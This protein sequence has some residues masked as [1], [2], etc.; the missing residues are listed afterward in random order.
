MSPT[1]G[2]K[3]GEAKSCQYCG[4][5]IPARASM[6]E[7]C[8][9]YLDPEL[10][11]SAEG[12]CRETLARVLPIAKA[13]KGVLWCVLVQLGYVVAAIAYLAASGRQERGLRQPPEVCA[14]WLALLVLLPFQIYF[15]Y[16]L[17]SALKAGPP[18][19]WALGMFA[20]YVSLVLMLILSVMATTAIRRRGFHVGLMGAK[21]SQIQTRVEQGWVGDI[22]DLV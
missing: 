6:C 15:I 17:A 22:G 10:R 19:L 3:S 4:K 16:R 20:P 1:A 2:A 14:L 21:I 11:A 12:S 8:G 18:I 9:Q 13:Q 7:Y 5:E